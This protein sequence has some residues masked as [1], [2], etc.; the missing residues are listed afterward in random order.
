MEYDT[1]ISL[2]NVPNT[3]LLLPKLLPSDFPSFL[4]LRQPNT[5]LNLLISQADDSIF[6][7]LPTFRRVLHVMMIFSAIRAPLGDGLA[8]VPA[9]A[10]GVAVEADILV[11]ADDAREH[12]ALTRP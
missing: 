1:H 2:R 7:S 10:S 12:G 3:L 6:D 11:S 5:K 9:Q 4:D 8:L